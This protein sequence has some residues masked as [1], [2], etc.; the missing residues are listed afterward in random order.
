[1]EA[2]EQL[3]LRVWRESAEWIEAGAVWRRDRAAYT[4]T[5]PDVMIDGGW[6]PNPRHGQQSGRSASW[7]AERQA[8]IQP[9][10]VPPDPEAT[11]FLARMQDLEAQGV[12]EW[13]NDQWQKPRPKRTGSAATADW[14]L[15][16][17]DEFLGKFDKVR[18]S[19]KRWWKALC[20]AHDDHNPSLYLS[21]GDRWWIIVCQSRHCLIEAI[22]AAV[23]L[24]V[25]QLALNP[26]TRPS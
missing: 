4:D 25:S 12:V 13:R 9:E 16:T 8:I 15:L 5:M 6:Q 26:P 3:R 11:A 10:Q 21:R 22:C 19:G 14:K 23:G 17:E 24:Q 20:P 1:M 18:K 7:D 2:D